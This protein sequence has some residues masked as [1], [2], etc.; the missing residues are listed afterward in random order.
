MESIIIF[1][2]LLRHFDFAFSIDPKDVSLN[3]RVYVC[4]YVYIYVYMQHFVR[5]VAFILYVFSIHIHI[6]SLIWSF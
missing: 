1:T 6:L 5:M 4:M 3:T 2:H